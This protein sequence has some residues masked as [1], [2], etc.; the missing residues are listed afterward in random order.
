MGVI[1]ELFWSAPR[2]AMEF[3]KMYNAIIDDLI[4]CS[5]THAKSWQVAIIKYLV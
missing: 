3:F 4:K 1:W 5:A 2:K